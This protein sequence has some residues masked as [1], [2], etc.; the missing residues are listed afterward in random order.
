M[1]KILVVDDEITM[2]QITSEL[3]RAEGHEVFSS[4]NL[5]SAMA[6]LETHKPELVITDLYLEKAKPVGLTLLAKAA[7]MNPPPVVIVITGFGTV[8]MAVEAMRKGAYHY[9]QKPF[10]LDEFKLLIQRAL[11]SS[12]K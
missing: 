4:S 1:A 7:A 3:L 12:E 11:S 2:I 9:L 8:E 10:K 5:A 6:L